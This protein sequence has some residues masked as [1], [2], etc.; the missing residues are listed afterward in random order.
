MPSVLGE[1]LAPEEAIAYWKDKVL[2][3]D[4]EA[5]KL[6]GGAKSRAFYVSGLAE[7]DQVSTVHKAL[8]SA[9][10]NGDTLQDFKKNIASVIDSHGWRSHRVKTIFQTN[11]QT[12]YSAGRYAQM[13][14]VKRTRPY[15]Q[16]ASILDNRTR[17]NHAVLHG[18]VYPAHHAFWDSH[19]PPNGFR[20][21]C[22]VRTLSERQVGREKLEI[23]DKMP[24]TMV[25][26]DPKT[27]ME[28]F[29]HAPKPDKGFSQNVGKDWLGGLDLEKYPS[30]TKE[31]YG[32]Q[33][34]IETSITPSVLPAIKAVK[35]NDALCEAIQ[36]HCSQFAT[37]AGL[38]R[39]SIARQDYFLATNSNGLLMISNKTHHGGFNATKNL[40][41]GWNKIANKKPMTWDEEYAFE[42]LWHELIHNQQKTGDLG[43][44]N[45]TKRRNMEIVTQWTARRTYQKLLKKLGVKPKHQTEIIKQGLGYQGMIS[46]FDTLLK[47]LKIKNSEMLPVMENLIQ[48]APRDTYESSLISF[49][50]EKSGLGK[51]VLEL[52]LNATGRAYFEK[53]LKV[54][55][56]QIKED[57]Q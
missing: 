43:K 35:T 5:K 24:S 40:K 53:I 19:Y 8:Q 23:Q 44:G 10:E 12:A 45:S 4:N 21:R 48:N 32:E 49:M 26:T 13:Q 2:F 30:L 14:K 42:G 34:G 37:N 22:T 3:S 46:D 39:V 51:G 20:C 28:S 31:S 57:L 52:G 11:M 25:Y 17:P 18:L 15:W 7:L 55:D 50:Q 38:K 1:A 29:V 6:M 41:S 56:T 36:E 27:G 47:T 54:I 16:M 33:R 9:L